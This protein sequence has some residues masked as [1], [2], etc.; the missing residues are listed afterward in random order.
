MSMSD[1]V[2]AFP[3]LSASGLPLGPTAEYLPVDLHSVLLAENV[4]LRAELEK[5]RHQPAPIIL[6]QQALPVSTAAQACLG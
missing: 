2:T 1:T 6:Q 4:K 5:S 3:V